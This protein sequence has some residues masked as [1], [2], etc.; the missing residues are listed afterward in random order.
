MWMPLNKVEYVPQM[1]VEEHDIE[2]EN[3]SQ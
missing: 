1:A 2:N 3:D